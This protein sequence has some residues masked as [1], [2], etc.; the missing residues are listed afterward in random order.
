MVDTPQQYKQ[1][2]IFSQIGFVIIKYHGTSPQP[3]RNISIPNTIIWGRY[4]T[5]VY[6]E[7]TNSLVKQ[8]TQF[9]DE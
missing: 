9:T 7:F 4:I 2:N 5:R 3:R 6:F 8:S 1:S